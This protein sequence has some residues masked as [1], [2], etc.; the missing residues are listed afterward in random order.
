[1]YYAL[2]TVSMP[3]PHFARIMSV[4][5]VQTSVSPAI[6]V[7]RW[8]AQAPDG[9]GPGTG[10]AAAGATGGAEVTK[11]QILD[12]SRSKFVNLVGLR[13]IRGLT[14]GQKRVTFAIEADFEG[15]GHVEWKGLKV[16]F[17]TGAGMSTQIIPPVF[18]LYSTTSILRDGNIRRNLCPAS[19][20]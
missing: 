17:E 16:T 15:N 7:L 8:Y 18:A 6:R 9:A 10:G 2:W 5:P 1:M 20:T 13:G 3:G 12:M 19:P 11:T 4:E 14:V